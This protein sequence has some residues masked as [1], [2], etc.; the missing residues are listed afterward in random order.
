MLER[1]LTSRAT[2]CLN[3]LARKTAVVPAL[4]VLAAAL[5][6]CDKQMPFY[7]NL[8]EQ[9]ANKVLAVLMQAGISCSKESAEEGMW[10]VS[11]SGNRFADAVDLVRDAGL[12][13]DEYMGVGEVFKKTGMVSSP[14]EERIRFMHALSE[15]LAKTL[16]EIDGVTAARV[17]VVLPENT[18]FSKEVKASSASVFVKYRYDVDMESRIP[19][20]KNL[21]KDSIEGLEYENISL[22]LFRS[23]PPP[24]PSSEKTPLVPFLGMVVAQES[25]GGLRILVGALAG[26]CALLIAALAAVVWLTL[27]RKK[28]RPAG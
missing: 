13:G 5:S 4:I 8:D 3:N 1:D 26:G 15:D 23:D 27:F 12:P 6:A 11:V 16:C 21:V 20:I 9:R 24:A 19:F 2:R 17:H 14:T 18:P 25:V 10:S 28:K 7:G 22:A